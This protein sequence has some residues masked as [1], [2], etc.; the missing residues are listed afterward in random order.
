M[1][2]CFLLFQLSGVPSGGS[3]YPNQDSNMS[4]GS[5]H[6]NDGGVIVPSDGGAVGGPNAPNVAPP[7]ANLKGGNTSLKVEPSPEKNLN[8]HPVPT[9][10]TPTERKRKRKGNNSSAAAMAAA[11]AAAAA[12]ANNASGAAGGIPNLINPPDGSDGPNPGSGGKGAKKINDYFKHS[13]PSSPL[14]Q[15]YPGLAY[16]TSPS[17]G[18]TAVPFGSGGAAGAEYL[19][20]PQQSPRK[21]MTSSSPIGIPKS[22]QTDLTMESMS[23]LEAR[24]SQELE[25]KENRIEELLRMNEELTRQ[26]AAKTKDSDEKTNTIN[27]CLTVAKEL[28]IEK[29]GIEKKDARA[30]CMQNRLRLGQFVTQRVG[31]TFQENWTDGYAFQEL[32]K[33]QEEINNEREDIE[34]K[35]KMLV[36]RKPS[37]AVSNRKRS[38]S[39]TN[40]GGNGGSANSNSSSGIGS[41]AGG[42]S[43][44]CSGAGGSMSGS[45]GGGSGGAIVPPSPGS[46]GGRDSCSSSAVSG[47]NNG[48]SDETLFTKPPPRDGMTMQEYYEAEEILRLRLNSLKKEDAEMQL[49]M[50]KLERSRN[51]HIRELKRIHNEDQSRYNNHPMLNERYLLLMLLGKGG[52]SEVHKV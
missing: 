38:S 6:S 16:P 22:M 49:E 48:A 42:G 39:N 12:A 47:L 21:V 30:Q 29:S 18:P 3:L 9:A 17:G 50:E 19:M 11:A 10:R 46:S 7:T 13:S 31:A 23:E 33:R 51:L 40:V 44:N 34:K 36:K 1:Y 25:T 14:R 41:S 2:Y 37:E 28:L 24:S 26:L 15:N 4:T 43:G 32:G 5:S 52:F 27:K 20:G 35:K 45:G 8:H